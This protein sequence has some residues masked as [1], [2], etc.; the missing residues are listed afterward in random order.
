MNITDFIISA[1]RNNSN[2]QRLIRFGL[3]GSLGTIVNLFVLSCSVKLLDISTLIALGM[4]IEISIIFNFLLN[5]YYT[6]NVALPRSTHVKRNDSK[7]TFMIKMVKYNAGALGGAT[8]SFSTFSLLFKLAHVEY[9]LADA[10]SILF[11]MSWNYW[12][13]IKYVWRIVDR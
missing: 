5:H 11:A 4:A 13:S 7:K 8:I 10:I 1:S 9:L 2:V 6:F 12:I 3:V